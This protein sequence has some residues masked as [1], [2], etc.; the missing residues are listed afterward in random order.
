[1]TYNFCN[2]LLCWIYDEFLECLIDFVVGTICAYRFLVCSISFCDS[3]AVALSG[4]TGVAPV[5]SG[6][7]NM[8]VARAKY[9]SFVVIRPRWPC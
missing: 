8:S 6:A 9:S 7:V 3:A 4:C 2:L 1:V 5:F